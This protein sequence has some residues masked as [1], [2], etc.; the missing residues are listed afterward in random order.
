MPG[1]DACPSNWRRRA[2]LPT[3]DP[4]E[5]QYL[6]YDKSSSP[7]NRPDDFGVK[8]VSFKLHRVVRAQ[9]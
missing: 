7:L 5:I 2:I 8:D 6:E 4:E 1:Q 3:G 9:E